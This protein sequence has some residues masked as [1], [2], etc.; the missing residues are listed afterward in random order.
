[1]NGTAGAFCFDV[2]QSPDFHRIQ[3][4]VT[5]LLNARLYLT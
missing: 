2:N 5:V 1:V 3:I 4:H